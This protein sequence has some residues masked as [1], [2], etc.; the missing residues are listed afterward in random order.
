MTN[1]SSGAGEP[2]EPTGVFKY[3]ENHDVDEGLV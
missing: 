3:L 1:A 2:E